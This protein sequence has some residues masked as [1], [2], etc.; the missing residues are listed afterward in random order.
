V[1]IPAFEKRASR[2]MCDAKESTFACERVIARM[3]GGIGHDNG[4]GYLCRHS[5]W[6][7]VS[8]FPDEREGEQPRCTSR[9]KISM[10]MNIPAE[11]RLMFPRPRIMPARRWK[12]TPSACD[13]DRKPTAYAFPPIGS[14]FSDPRIS[15]PFWSLATVNNFNTASDSPLRGST[16][17]FTLSSI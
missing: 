12:H 10:G 15:L 14:S 6:G 11:G 2:T 13:S 7:E 4:R 9:K 8:G 17:A 3:G 1:G 5:F 16:V